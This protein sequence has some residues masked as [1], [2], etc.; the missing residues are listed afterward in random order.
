MQLLDHVTWTFILDLGHTAYDHVSL[1]D[2]SLHTN[3][4]K[5]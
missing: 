1:I 3:F 2:L 4:I 5:F